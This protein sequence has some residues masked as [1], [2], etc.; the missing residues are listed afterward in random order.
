[1]KINT[2]SL[3]MTALVMSA[4]GLVAEEYRTVE[5]FADARRRYNG[6]WTYPQDPLAS[7]IYSR[8]K[9]MYEGHWLSPFDYF[10]AVR[11]GGVEMEMETTNFFTFVSFVSNNCSA[12]AADWPTYETNEMV[13]FTTLSAIAY[14]GFDRMTNLA[15]RVLAG[16]EANTNYCG[17]D[18]IRFINCPYGTRATKQYLARNYDVPGVSNLLQ[19][20]R[21][22]AVAHGNDV[23]RDDCDEC[24]SGESKKHVLEM[25]SI[26]AEWP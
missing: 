14:S 11:G 7:N 19:R 23:M 24:L 13:R 15:D 6:E 1:M 3:C 22:L 26:G 16:Y 8:V 4:I 5:E 18:T 25:I 17:W 20:I 2:A 9:S 12:I 10:L 21:A